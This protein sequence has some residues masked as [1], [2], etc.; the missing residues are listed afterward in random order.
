MYQEGEKMRLIKLP[1]ALLALGLCVQGVHV[2]AASAYVKVSNE[3]NKAYHGKYRT[4][5][6]PNGHELVTNPPSI[7][8]QNTQADRSKPLY[9]VTLTS[10]DQPSAVFQSGWLN[11]AV[12][13]P[14]KA[15]AE[16]KWQW[17]VETKYKN[18]VTTEGPYFF[19]VN[20]GLQTYQPLILTPLKIEKQLGK[21]PRF[22]N[23]NARGKQ[24]AQ[25]IPG[26]LQKTILT[27]A[28]LFLAPEST[29]DPFADVD[30]TL[31][32][33]EIKN[34]KIVRAKILLNH[35]RLKV[36]YLAQ[37]FALTGDNKYATAALEKYQL[38]KGLDKN[39]FKLNDFT[40]GM[41]LD[42]TLYMFDGFYDQLSEEQR[43]E[44][45]D[46]ASPIARHEYEHHRSRME[47]VLFD[48]HAWQ[49]GIALLAR[50]SLI[51][52]NHVPD[53]NQWMAYVSAIWSARAPAGGFSR[54]GGWINGNNY[55]TANVVSLIQT[56]MILNKL[57]GFDYLSHPWYQNLGQAMLTTYQGRSY[58]NGF[59]DGHDSTTMPVWVRAQLAKY[60]AREKNS[61]EMSWYA[62]QLGQS[63]RG[64]APTV[65][66]AGDKHPLDSEAHQWLLNT[67]AKPLPKSVEP[68]FPRA[69]VFPDTGVASIHSNLLDAKD[70]M[71][72]ALRSSPYGS[73]SHTLNNQNA[74]NV[75]VGGKPLFLSSGFYTSFADKHNLLHY[76]NT[77][78]HNTVLVNGVGQDIGSHAAGSIE[79]SLFSDNVAYIQSDAT[80]AYQG[81]LN[82]PMWIKKM[83]QSEVEFSAEN[84]YGKS[85]LT[86]FKRHLL[87]LDKRTVV[88]YDELAASEAVRFDWL[89][90]SPGVM[91]KNAEQ[92]VVVQT[93]SAKAKVQ[94]HA[95][96]P[97]TIALTNEF[98]Y[99][100]KNWKGKRKNGALVE[101]PQQQ[102]LTASSE[103]TK[104]LYILSVLSVDGAGHSAPLA[105]TKGNGQ[106][107]IGNWTVNANLD[108]AKAPLLRATNLKTR[109][110][111]SLVNTKQT[112]GISAELTEY[113]IKTKA[114]HYKVLTSN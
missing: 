89:L 108:V 14:E 76:R 56:P 80:L 17:T 51:L 74:F 54:D 12:W 113:G 35:L 79:A 107:I 103:K 8:W 4:S 99:P 114:T 13:K 101:Y 19:T 31:K 75:I 23:L 49:K 40:A 18:N 21:H 62:E 88:I 69:K 1:V 66:G 65:Y 67:L 26:E 5:G 28:D 39:V 55:M 34:Q 58:S 30:F 64:I 37:A 73:G 100:A 91:E 46:F 112:A 90:H 3:Y 53:A 24:I 25:R 43:Q 98:H 42:L 85:A 60:I 20:D 95:S 109:A 111:F 82:D 15:L 2:K 72:V 63:E 71:H 78:G 7:L 68:S 6:Y 41:A 84:G 83:A 11:W 70:N 92:M 38:F 59:G 44:L 36:L 48:N 50:A 97:M 22:F 61:G 94:I 29:Q 27:N 96:V 9:Q 106:F 86:R 45:I 32:P 93:D 104:K 16:G 87:V 81:V 52:G 33:H 102:H 57:S 77:R 105:I 47:I 110:I 10:V